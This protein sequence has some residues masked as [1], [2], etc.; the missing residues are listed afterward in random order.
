MIDPDRQDDINDIDEIVS[1]YLDRINSGETLNPLEILAEHPGLGGEIL[2][3][4]Q[5][6]HSLDSSGAAP[7]LGTLGDYTLRRQIG[8]GGMGVVYDAWQNSMDRRVA[9]KVL[10][11][12]VAVDEK[13]FQRF[14]REARTA[15]RLDHPNV[16]HVHGLGIDEQT[17]YYAMEYV[18]GQTL[19]QILTG[20]KDAEPET[21]TVFGKKERVGYFETLADAFADVSDGLQHAHSKGVIHRDVKPSNLILDSEGRLR[22]LDFGLARLEGQESLTISGDFIGTPAYV[23]PEQARRQKI[24]IDHRTDIYSLG[25]TL[26]EMLISRPPFRGGDH[27]DTLSQIIE[28]DPTEPRKINPRV[29]K[30]LETIVLKCLRKEP[31]D[32]YGT[33]EALAQ[34]LRRF[35]RGDPIEARPQS[36]WERLGSRVR[37][38][39]T[40][41]AVGGV[42][43]VLVLSVVWLALEK[44]RADYDRQRLEYDPA[45]LDLVKQI[46]AHQY[47]LQ[48]VEG[49]LDDLFF[50]TSPSRS[51]ARMTPEEVKALWKDRG[52]HPV[53][54]AANELEPIAEAVAK[55]DA[56][57]HLAKAYLLLGREEDAKKE[58]Q[59][60]LEYDEFVPAKVLEFESPW[61]DETGS[62]FETI[63][64]EQTQADGWRRAWFEARKSVRE[65]ERR[66]AADE[67]GKL[68]ALRER[69]REPYVGSAIEAHI[70]RGMVHLELKDYEMAKLDFVRAETLA[71]GLVEGV[72]LLGIWRE[73]GGP[74]G[75]SLLSRLPSPLQLS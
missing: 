8:R 65:K 34:D 69:G 54:Q 64:P 3:D 17:P 22:V 30:D 19:A 38:H 43:L 26:Y 62:D 52:V 21:D 37:R 45:V 53:E 32:R 59:K 58:L 23:S 61:L 67:Y 75:Q 33:A 29:P 9:L 48:A 70:G 42:F 57:Y 28:R 12:G 20:L 51:L 36:Q 50:K 24:P 5:T 41:F 7:P 25:A 74:L 14:M 10:P 6:Y 40:K 73:D 60:A 71:P 55:P 18:E 47:S 16:V 72:L 13:A 46:Y 66:R 44:R 39:R 35:V 4:L 2:K 15:G 27:A 63:W 56:H 49:Q 68:I 1:R 11:V 31:E